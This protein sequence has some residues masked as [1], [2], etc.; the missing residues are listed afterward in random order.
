MEGIVLYNQVRE[1]YIQ[2]ESDIY[3]I[4]IPHQSQTKALTYNLSKGYTG[5]KS[6]KIALDLVEDAFNLFLQ[7]ANNFINNYIYI[8]D[9][10]IQKTA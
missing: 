7:N 2:Y 1:K 4:D 5:F 10:I 6:D 8:N 9:N 3:K